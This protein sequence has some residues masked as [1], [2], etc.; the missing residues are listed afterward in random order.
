MLFPVCTVV[1]SVNLAE[2][3][4]FM[5]NTDN[6]KFCEFVLE[7]Q[8]NFNGSNTLWTMKISSRQG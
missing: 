5:Q 8:S 7:V 3:E 4:M 2:T 1:M 6:K